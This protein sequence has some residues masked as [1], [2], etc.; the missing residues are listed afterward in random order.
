[1]LA[2]ASHLVLGAEHPDTI[3]SRNSLAIG[4]RGLGRHEEAVD[5]DEETLRLRERVLG[6]EHPHTLMSRNDLAIGYRAVGRDND[7]DELESRE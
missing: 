6:T 1:M 3:A 4:Y 2:R 5:L 7:A